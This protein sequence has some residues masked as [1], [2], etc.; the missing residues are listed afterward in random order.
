MRL[1]ERLNNPTAG[2]GGNSTF[3]PPAAACLRGLQQQQ[4]QSNSS[5][6]G[7]L[8]DHHHHSSSASASLAATVAA[9][10]N[11]TINSSRLL[12]PVEVPLANGNG[13]ADG[14]GQQHSAV[15]PTSFF[16]PLMS[17]L[18]PYTT[19]ALGATTTKSGG[20]M[21][22]GVEGWTSSTASM[23]PW[24]TSG[25]LSSAAA[26]VVQSSAA[27]AILAAGGYD[28]T[29]TMIPSDT[30]S[31]SNSSLFNNYNSYLGM[32]FRGM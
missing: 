1:T 4:Q 30:T 26:D 22:A 32:T 3:V 19:M 21:S 23:W 31:N 25:G 11:N 13:T 7:A 17:S 20:G 8:T 28:T 2:G 24:N 15:Y 27:E 12:N 9:Q 16:D 6:A 29:K 10:V 5:A 18:S 14:F